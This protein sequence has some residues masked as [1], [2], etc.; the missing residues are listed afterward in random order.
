MSSRSPTA[1]TPGPKSSAPDTPVVRDAPTTPQAVPFP[2]PQTFDFIPPL[3][4]LILRLLS[5]Q[6]SGEGA[7][8]AQGAGGNDESG[9]GQGQSQPQPTS[10]VGNDS[11]TAELLGAVS[12]SA[13]GPTSAA[14]D[15]A[16]LGSNLSPPLDIKNLPKEV[17]SIKIRI[18]K[19]QAV[20]EN[21]PDVDRTVTEQEMEIQE[22]EDRILRLKSVISDFG[23]R[24][25]NAI[26]G[27]PKPSGS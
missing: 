12:S 11:S 6:T 15:I 5:P 17:S 13:P 26:A 16:A 22:L 25:N 18:Q 9:P 8:N 3:H 10:G 14:A 1:I 2:P 4:G 24:A 21:L 19:A 20:V 27:K 7:T 23:R